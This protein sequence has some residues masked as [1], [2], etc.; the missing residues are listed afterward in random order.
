MLTVIVQFPIL[1]RLSSVQLEFVKFPF[2]MML[3]FSATRQQ[4]PQIK[5]TK[6]MTVLFSE[7][8]VAVHVATLYVHHFQA[9]NMTSIIYNMNNICIDD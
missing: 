3:K 8:D 4:S 7:S 5:R 1:H 9:V 2:L 6:I